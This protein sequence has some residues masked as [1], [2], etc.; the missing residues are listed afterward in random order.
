VAGEDCT[1]EFT[2]LDEL[3]KLHPEF[4]AHSQYFPDYFGSVFKSPELQNYELIRPFSQ[5]AEGPLPAEIQSLL[6]WSK[7]G[8]RVPGAYPPQP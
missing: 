4:E 2:T 1:A 3:R 7:A 8:P 6:G 5:P